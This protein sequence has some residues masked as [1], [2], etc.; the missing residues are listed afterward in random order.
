MVG[1]VYDSIVSKIEDDISQN[2][3]EFIEEGE[4]HIVGD[5]SSSPED[6]ATLIPE[7]LAELEG[8]TDDITSSLGFKVVDTV[9]DFKGDNPAAQFEAGVSCGGNYPYMVG[10][11]HRNRFS[12]FSHVTN[13]QDNCPCR[14][15]W[16][17]VWAPQVL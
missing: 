5:G 16:K 12:D 15:F 1:V 10:A 6:Q 13:C 17:G 11:S 8:L 2:V 9:H 4:V 14:A 3:Q 7:H